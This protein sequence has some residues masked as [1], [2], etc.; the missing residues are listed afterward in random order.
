MSE[1]ETDVIDKAADH[2]DALD[3]LG[4]AL[5]AELKK[6]GERALA[7]NAMLRRMGELKAQVGRP[8]GSGKAKKGGAE[9]QTE[10]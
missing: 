1:Y 6:C 10:T 2:I 7:I 4:P 9:Q 8:R 5:K 3:Q